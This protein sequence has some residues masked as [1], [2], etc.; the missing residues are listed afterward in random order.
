MP[1]QEGRGHYPHPYKRTKT[2][3]RGKTNTKCRSGE[4]GP[5][6]PVVPNRTI[7]VSQGVNKQEEDK[8]LVFLNK[9]KDVFA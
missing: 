6:D 3:Q 1:H 9:N 8:F 7:L 4:K 5:L 2:Q